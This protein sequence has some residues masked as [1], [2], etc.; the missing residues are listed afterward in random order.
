MP[1]PMSNKEPPPSAE[2]S[3]ASTI[4]PDEDS[5]TPKSTSPTSWYKPGIISKPSKKSHSRWLSPIRHW[6]RLVRLDLLVMASCLIIGGILAKWTSTFRQSD[7]LWPMWR[8]PAERVWRGPLEI[9]HPEL[10]S[11]LDSMECAIVVLLVPLALVLLMQTFVK[12]F[13]DANAAIL[14]LLKALSA[15]TVIQVVLKQY[16]IRLRPF[17]LTKCRPIPDVLDAKFRSLDGNPSRLPLFVDISVCE[18]SRA[19]LLSSMQS[20]PSGHTGSAFAV[21]IFLALYLN[22]KLKAFADCGTPFWKMMIVMAPVMGA[23]IIAA[24]LVI[25]KVRAESI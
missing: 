4:M 3:T 5:R 6:H 10:H 8:D 13:W 19:E 1:N 18:S 22:A 15:M 25:D 21:G 24:G 14:G 20:F 7:T 2:Q 17:F 12:S 16:I 11:V 23:V 9:S